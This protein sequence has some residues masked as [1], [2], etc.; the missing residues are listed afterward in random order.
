MWIVKLLPQRKAESSK[1]DEQSKHVIAD[2]NTTVVQC[3]SI[4]ADHWTPMKCRDCL[5]FSDINHP[6]TMT[7]LALKTTK[8]EVM[9]EVVNI[10]PI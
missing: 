7:L 8:Q 5:E 9:S 10:N 1:L 2:E 6:A 4:L 3:K